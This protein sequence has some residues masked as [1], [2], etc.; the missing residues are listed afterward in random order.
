MAPVSDADL[1]EL[2]RRF[3]ETGSVEDEAAWL[4][5]RVKTGDLEQ[6]KLEL[7]AYCGHQAAVE[8]AGMT[9]PPHFKTSVHFAL[10]LDQCGVEGIRRC[11]YA[12]LG[13]M[14]RMYRRKAEAY[15]SARSSE[16]ASKSLR[17]V[18]LFREHQALLGEWITSPSTA[19]EARLEGLIGPPSDRVGFVVKYV[20]DLSYDE[21]HFDVREEIGAQLVPWALGYAD[22]VRERVVAHKREAAG[23]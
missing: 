2:E 21:D 15:R 10:G 18:D 16:A 4:R 17:L 7:A 9:D 23:E 12:V 6:S 14:V 8:A 11:G 22:P 1:R 3:R 13:L 5:A 19:T 20:R